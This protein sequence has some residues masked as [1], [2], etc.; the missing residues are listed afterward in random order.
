MGMGTL[1]SAAIALIVQVLTGNGSIW[2]WAIPVG[3]ATGLAIGV[4]AANK[5]DSE[6]RKEL[7]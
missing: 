6:T 2:S 4:S 3:L 5:N 7:L 1:I